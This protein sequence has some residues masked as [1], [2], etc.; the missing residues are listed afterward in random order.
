MSPPELHLIAP[1]SSCRPFFPAI[2]VGSAAGLID[3][4]QDCVGSGYVVSGDEALID[5]EEDELDGGRQD[6][7]RRVGDLERALGDPNVVAV[8][9]MRGGAWFT[10]I[11]PRIDFSGLD[12]RG[13]AVAVFGFSELTPLVNIA[14]GRGYGLGTYD[15]GPAFLTYGLKRYASVPPG[16]DSLE[17]SSRED[18]MLERVRPELRAFFQDVVS[19]IE[20]RGTT[21]SIT[22]RLA[23]GEL[24]DRSEAI[25]VGGNLTVLSTL[26]G[27]EYAA[28]V[29]PVARWLILED[30]NDKI[31]RV[32]RFLAHLTL[33][34][35]W[36]RCAGVLLGDFHKGYADHTPAVISLLRYHLPSRSLP[37]LTTRQ[38]GHVWPMSPLP[39]H[40]PLKIEQVDESRFSIHWPPS[41][42][43]TVDEG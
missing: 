7:R 41:L 43:Q 23:Q 14:G 8:I 40:Q 27:S 24:P 18:W 4:V 22:A 26:I 21:R 38:V 30:F 37:I 11:L 36:D 20:G 17:R 29:D 5:A 13:G 16:S 34:G 28:Y 31:E 25:F 3:V 9:A 42:L 32:D 35:W 2:G 15:M 1:A 6:D 33:A 10:R 12:T 19:M 39:L